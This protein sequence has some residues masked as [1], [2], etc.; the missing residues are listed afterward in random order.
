V[1][2]DIADQIYQWR[3]VIAAE[4]LLPIVKKTGMAV[5]GETL[6]H[7][8]TFHAA[9]EIAIEA[10]T[11]LPRPVLDNPLNPWTKHREMPDAPKQT[12]H[13]W[14]EKNRGKA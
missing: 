11:H 13:E 7:A 5:L 12:F 6:A 3:R 4:G 1:R 14:F 2:I 9:E 10:V 8:G